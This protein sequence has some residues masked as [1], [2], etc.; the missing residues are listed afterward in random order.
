MIPNDHLST[1][2]TFS[3]TGRLVSV[4]CPEC[5]GTLARRSHRSGLAEEMF[6]LIYLYPFRCQLCAHRFFALQWGVHYHRV[7]QHSGDHPLV[8]TPAKAGPSF[9]R[10]Q[11]ALFMAVRRE[12][13]QTRRETG[14]WSLEGMRHPLGRTLTDREASPPCHS[15]VSASAAEAFMNNAG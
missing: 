3:T 7:P 12:L 15:S 10:H 13:A 6:S 5:G 11:P 4:P 8:E 9:S 1:G 14:A 2:A